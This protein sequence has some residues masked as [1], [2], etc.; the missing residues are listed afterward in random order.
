[1]SETAPGSVSSAGAPLLCEPKKSHK[2]Q[3]PAGDRQRFGQA[4]MVA[5]VT[6]WQRDAADVRQDQTCI[7]NLKPGGG[8]GEGGSVFC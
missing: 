8:G 6:A 1:M 2:P 3:K 5:V 4:V 7:G